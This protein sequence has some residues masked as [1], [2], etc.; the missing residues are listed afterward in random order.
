LG[1]D[2]SGSDSDD[3]SSSSDTCDNV[4][5]DHVLNLVAKTECKERQLR[6]SARS[7]RSAR[8]TTE[9]APSKPGR[10]RKSHAST[11]ADTASKDTAS[12]GEVH[13]LLTLV[14]EIEVKREF[15][16]VNHTLMPSDI[17]MTISDAML[18]MDYFPTASAGSN[19]SAFSMSTAVQATRPV[20]SNTKF[21]TAV[22]EYRKKDRAA[23]GLTTRSRALEGLNQ[24]DDD[25]E[26]EKEDSAVLT[27]LGE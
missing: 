9:A 17:T 14:K 8:A 11:P 18:K 3:S 5:A 1:S 2:H 25:S 12:A 13:P 4:K 7:A 15:V 21:F 16:R 10:A 26:Q 6:R 27:L 24:S 23:R 20:L 19:T 22:N